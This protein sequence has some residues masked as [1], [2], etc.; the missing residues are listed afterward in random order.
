ME[1]GLVYEIEQLVRYIYSMYYKYD[2]VP[3][4]LVEDEGIFP[5]QMASPLDEISLYLL[6]TLL[7]GQPSDKAREG[8]NNVLS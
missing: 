7:K 3:T 8:T 5:T 2:S 6:Q 1:Q 4:L